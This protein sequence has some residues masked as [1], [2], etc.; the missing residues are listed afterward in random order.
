[1]RMFCGVGD[2]MHLWGCCEHQVSVECKHTTRQFWEDRAS[3]VRRD[4][5]LIVACLP[6]IQ[7]HC[8]ETDVGVGRVLRCLKVGWL[9]PL[10]LQCFA[11]SW[12]PHGCVMIDAASVWK[13]NYV[14]RSKP[15]HCNC[16]RAVVY[17]FDNM[18][19]MHCLYAFCD[20]SLWK[21]WPTLASMRSPST[22]V[23]VHSCCCCMERSH[24]I[25]VPR[26]MVG[27]VCA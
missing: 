26:A 27:P 16:Y 12:C 20:H 5:P 22:P 21:G 7:K 18:L 19:G 9:H 14:S 11:H 2:E 10:L 4:M 1:M 6:D 13:F 24:M 17:C 3:D 23:Y 8:N 25:S 15:S